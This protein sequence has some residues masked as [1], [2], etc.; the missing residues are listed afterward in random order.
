MAG[1]LRSHRAYYHV[2]VMECLRFDIIRGNLGTDESNNGIQFSGF[3]L[4]VYLIVAFS[5]Q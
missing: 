1:D 3:P 4:P 5:G 2:I